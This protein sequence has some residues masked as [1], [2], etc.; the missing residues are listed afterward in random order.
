MFLYSK[1]HAEFY[2]M[3]FNLNIICRFFTIN[4]N[5]K[6]IF[7]V[8]NWFCFWFFQKVSEF[9]NRNFI[10]LLKIDFWYRRHFKTKRLKSAKNLFITNWYIMRKILL[11]AFMQL[12]CWGLFA[13]TSIE[14]AQ[15][16]VPGVNTCD[17]TGTGYVSAYFKYME[18][19][20]SR[21]LVSVSDTAT[22]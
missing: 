20:E 8:K 4:Y 12:C 13:Q 10:I 2:C 3:I 1:R 18:P 16:L 7:C 5:L 21:Q 19:A 9:C 15:D 11:F 14:T 6:L 17:V 22:S